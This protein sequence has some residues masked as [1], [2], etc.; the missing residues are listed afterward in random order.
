MNSNTDSSNKAA[1]PNDHASITD[2]LKGYFHSAMAMGQEALHK[3]Q[4]QINHATGHDQ[5]E[6]K[7][8]AQSNEDAFAEVN[9]FNANAKL[10]KASENRAAMQSNTDAFAEVNQFNADCADQHPARHPG[11]K[12][13]K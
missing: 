8:T 2:T 4:E 3:A 10:P 11:G 1:G 9:Q 13:S 5:A 12:S 6:T 7:P